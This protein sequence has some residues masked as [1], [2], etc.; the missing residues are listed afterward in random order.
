MAREELQAQFDQAV[1]LRGLSSRLAW[2]EGVPA[3]AYFRKH[4][5]REPDRTR[6]RCGPCGVVLCL[7]LFR[8]GE[9]WF[10]GK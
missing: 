8:G 9:V 10:S 5:D 4:A 6:A 2:H 7:G 1:V 3:S